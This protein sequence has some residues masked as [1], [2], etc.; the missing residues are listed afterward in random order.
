MLSDVLTTKI[1]R[2]KLLLLDVDGVMTDGKIYFSNGG[3][4]SWAFDVRDGSG[5]RYLTRAGV[6]VGIVTGKKN[7]AVSHRANDLDLSIVYKNVMNK[8]TVLSEILLKQ[9]LLPEEVAFVGDDLLDL[10]VMERVGLSIAVAD[11]A[12]EIKEAADFVTTKL[13][14]NGAVREVCEMILK[15]QGKWE[16]TVEHYRSMK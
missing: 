8:V 12:P 14:G 5:I 2:I 1:E 13:G 7:N 3:E 15:V 4:R 16:Q 9:N 10:P 11:A 6:Q